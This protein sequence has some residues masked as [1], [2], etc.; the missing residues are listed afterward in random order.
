MFCLNTMHI[1]FILFIVDQCKAKWKT[2]RERYGKELKK[3][4]PPS[5]SGAS[6][7]SEWAFTQEMSFL[8]DCVA[9]R[10]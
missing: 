9:P 4:N 5:G 8:K 1:L 7:S 10:K 3:Q 6:T 2:L